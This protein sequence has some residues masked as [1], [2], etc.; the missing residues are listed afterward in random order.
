M[1]I[2]FRPRSE[3]VDVIGVALFPGRLTTPGDPAAVIV[4]RRGVPVV[5]DHTVPG[6]GWHLCDFLRCH[7]DFTV[8]D[9]DALPPGV[10]DPRL[11][12]SREHWERNVQDPRRAQE[13]RDRQAAALDAGATG[14]VAP[15]RTPGAPSAGEL[16]QRQM[17]RDA[18][19]R[20]TREYWRRMERQ[21]LATIA[22]AKAWHDAHPESKQEVA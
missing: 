12:R 17:F 9:R 4:F 14:S 2:Q 10:E 3:S 22:E 19:E 7:R 11:R 8:I 1:K 20:S 18:E 21:A 16:H 13:Q 5:L 6:I 15:A